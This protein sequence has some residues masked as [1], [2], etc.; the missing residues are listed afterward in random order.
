MYKL[1]LVHTAGRDEERYICTSDPF[2]P[3]SSAKPTGRWNRWL[4]DPTVP[5]IRLKVSILLK[6]ER[7][8]SLAGSVSLL[9]P[10]VTYSWELFSHVTPKWWEEQ[11]GLGEPLRLILARRTEG[12][13]M[14]GR[15]E[16]IDGGHLWT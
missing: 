2:I 4:G 16:R 5:C 3:S 1:V 15:S 12:R 11:K 13:K 9:V 6:A 14:I 8:L 10:W 7:A